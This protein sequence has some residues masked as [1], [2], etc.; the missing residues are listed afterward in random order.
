M[1][2]S[3]STIVALFG[4][5]IV[6]AG[7]FAGKE[8]VLY[9]GR[10]L[11][12]AETRN[13]FTH[14]YLP[15]ADSFVN[16]AAPFSNYG[17]LR[18]IQLNGRRGEL[19]EG[20][21]KFNLN[22]ID[23]KV[24]KAVIRLVAGDNDR[25]N[26]PDVYLTENNWKETGLNYNNKPAKGRKVAVAR[27]IEIRRPVTIDVTSAITGKG[28]YSFVLAA[29]N[30]AGARFNSRE[31][32]LNKP[33]LTVTYSLLIPTLSKSPTNTP[34]PTKQPTPTQVPIITGPTLTATPVIDCVDSD[35]G[36]S[37]Y[38]RGEVEGLYP[39]GTSGRYTDSCISSDL[40]ALGQEN[41]IN[42]F[43]VNEGYCAKNEQGIFRIA[44]SL[45]PCDTGCANGAC[46]ISGTQT[47]TLTPTLIP[48]KP[49]SPS[50]GPPPLT[51]SAGKPGDANEDGFVDGVDYSIWQIN[52]GKTT[53]GKHKTGDFNNDGKV[54]GS[55]YIIWLNNYS[56]GPTPTT[57]PSA[58]PIITFTPTLIPSIA[59]T[60]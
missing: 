21:I 30:F 9:G 51:A 40:C 59:L 19:R 33:T 47:I 1:K 13:V 39:N 55:D 8:L 43:Y 26:S 44:N 32:I 27:N 3:I 53:E 29:G 2:G 48:S 18:S 5:G 22:N 37:I 23:G 17:K 49:P 10:F 24:T 15:V 57:V 45:K 4:L 46:I 7:I 42:R 20:Y 54:D 34:T 14:Y 25:K 58:A 52:Y 38:E 60:P 31:A 41:C 11:P 50:A 6:T 56:T 36:I 35:R 12:R 28:I 16:Q